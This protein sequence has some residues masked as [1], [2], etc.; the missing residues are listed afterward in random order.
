MTVQEISM[1]QEEANR[2]VFEGRKIHVEVEELA[3]ENRKP[4]EKTETGRAIGR[5]L[6]EDYT[7]SFKY[8]PTTND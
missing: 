1:I 5:G 2:L 3:A 7:V 4:V 6:P 8:L